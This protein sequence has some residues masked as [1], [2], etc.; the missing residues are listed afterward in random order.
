MFAYFV[1]LQCPS[2]SLSTPLNKGLYTDYQ[3]LI[4]A[5]IRFCI[6]K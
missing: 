1:S 5:D 4:F 2:E 3:L 6:G